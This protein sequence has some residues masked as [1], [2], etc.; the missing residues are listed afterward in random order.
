M[1]KTCLL[2]LI[3]LTFEQKHLQQNFAFKSAH[4]GLNRFC[5]D[6]VSANFIKNDFMTNLG[7]KHLGL[8]LKNA[9]HL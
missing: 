7:M 3:V 2:R 5:L 8:I 4:L 6:C 9:L 1:K